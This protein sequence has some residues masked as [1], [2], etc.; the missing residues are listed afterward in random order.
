MSGSNC[1]CNSHNSNNC[2][3]GYDH[4]GD[5]KPGC[6]V[7]K[8]NGCCNLKIVD[9]SRNVSKLTFLN[10]LCK[11]VVSIKCDD[12]KDCLNYDFE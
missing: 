3:C 9:Y 10:H 11:R 2:G 5:C 7:Y 6:D 12:A 4:E 8:T 1:N